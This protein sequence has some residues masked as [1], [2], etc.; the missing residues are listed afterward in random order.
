MAF[1]DI[2]GSRRGSRRP[3]KRSFMNIEE[4]RNARGAAIGETLITWKNREFGFE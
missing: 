3:Y 1:E 2:D 4:V